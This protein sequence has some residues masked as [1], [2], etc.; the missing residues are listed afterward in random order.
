MSNQHHYSHDPGLAKLLAV[1]A[2]KLGLESLPPQHGFVFTT[3]AAE[4]VQ[5]SLC[6]RETTPASNLRGLL[7]A[8]ESVLRNTN[9]GWTIQPNGKLAEIRPDALGVVE[10]PVY[11]H[12]AAGWPA[13]AGPSRDDGP[14]WFRDDFR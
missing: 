12:S 3:L 6:F 7:R 8:F 11:P 14:R 5:P 1:P 4:S 13:Q 9:C 2:V 10:I